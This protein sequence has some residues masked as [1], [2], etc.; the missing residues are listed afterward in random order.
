MKTKK[1]IY[2]NVLKDVNIS[3]TEP[4]ESST[5]SPDHLTFKYDPRMNY[6]KLKTEK[7]LMSSLQ[8]GIGT[9]KKYIPKVL[10]QGKEKYTLY[11]C[12]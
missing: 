12:Y 3:N 7:N 10:Q 8:K 1:I 9:K 5:F 2:V 11:I 6:I 4:K